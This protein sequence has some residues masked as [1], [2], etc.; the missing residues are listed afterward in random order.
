MRPAPC[1]SPNWFCFPFMPPPTLT[2]GPPFQAP[3]NLRVPRFALPPQPAQSF[4]RG[5]PAGHWSDPILNAYSWLGE[6]RT[7]E[8][9]GED[10]IGNGGLH[11]VIDTARGPLFGLGH[12]NWAMGAERIRREISSVLTDN[13]A[14]GVMAYGLGWLAA[15]P[16]MSLANANT[17]FESIHL[18]QHGVLQPQTHSLDEALAH[19][20][21]TLSPQKP[22]ALTGI[23]TKQALAQ[24]VAPDTKPGKPSFH[25]EAVQSLAEQ[26]A[27]ALGKSDFSHNLLQP[28]PG[29]PGQTE[30]VT[31]HFPTLI[32]DL[33]ILTHH[34]NEHPF[35][36]A[37]DLLQRALHW[38]TARVGLMVPGFLFSMSM[39]HLNKWLTNWLNGID[40]YPGEAGLATAHNPLNSRGYNGTGQQ[41][42]GIAPLKLPSRLERMFP[43]LTTQ[44]QQGN[45]W[46]VAAMA[47]PLLLA[48]GLFHTGS[49]RLV[50]PVWHTGQA[51]QTRL[52]EGVPLR[53]W[54]RRW[55]ASMDYERKFP[56]TTQQQMA[57]LFGGLISQRVG[58]SR[59]GNELRERMMDGLMGWGLWILGSPTLKPRLARHWFNGEHYELLQPIVQNGRSVGWRLR[60]AGEVK[61]FAGPAL[62][63]KGLSVDEALKRL[64]QVNASAF[65][66]NVLLLGILEP[67]LS[68][69]LTG[70]R[71][72][73]AQPPPEQAETAGG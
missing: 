38:K 6:T 45:Y 10:L 11:T 17:R 13:V 54:F 57:Q 48:S 50:L 66:L 72:R 47:A 32:E 29:L 56:F 9:I 19:V 40:Y 44:A 49:R 26:V 42:N 63:E 62:A 41:V 23:L 61:A 58:S 71:G 64:E 22:D 1:L 31:H 52:A 55:L 73:R 7:K 34:L 14:V 36:K 67:L 60:S 43:Y 37:P 30:P 24:V 4:G 46:P 51:F 59:S 68:I 33:A 35:G 70:W 5:V 12:L 2:S 39:P 20:A 18:L 21:R 28:I 65:G 27:K 8:M 15:T 16:V 53:Q 25:K 69:G 3:L